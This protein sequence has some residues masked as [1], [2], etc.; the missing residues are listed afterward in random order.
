MMD[1]IIGELEHGKYVQ[2]LM[3]ETPNLQAHPGDEPVYS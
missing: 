1:E 2:F 3:N